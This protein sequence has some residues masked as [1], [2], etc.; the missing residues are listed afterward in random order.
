MESYLITFSRGGTS[1][2]EDR[3]SRG[4]WN[5]KHCVGRW[6]PPRGFVKE[7]ELVLDPRSLEHALPDLIV[8]VELTPEK[9]SGRTVPVL[10]H[11]APCG[12][13]VHEAVNRLLLLC[14]ECPEHSIPDDEEPGVVFVQILWIPSVVHSV[15]G[16][17]VEDVLQR[18]KRF[19]HLRVDPELVD[20][21]QLIRR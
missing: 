21:V 13:R 2:G 9:R 16:G 6:V 3:I 15:V 5:R 18:A 11:D 10:P 19:H 17:R 4:T 14:L 7:L 1:D 8:V 12:K 20:Q